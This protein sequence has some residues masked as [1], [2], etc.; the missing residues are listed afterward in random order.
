MRGRVGKAVMGRIEIGGSFAARS[1]YGVDMGHWSRGIRATKACY[2]EAGVWDLI[3]AWAFA[4][5]WCCWT[6]ARPGCTGRRLSVVHVQ[7]PF[8]ARIAP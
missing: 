3:V 8:D 6:V 4:L 7:A 2:L 1:F 5:I